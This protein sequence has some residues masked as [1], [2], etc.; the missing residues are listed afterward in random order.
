M[1]TNDRVNCLKGKEYQIRFLHL[2]FNNY[3]S[4]VNKKF[5]RSKF[6]CLFFFFSDR[7]APSVSHEKY[8][9]F[10]LALYMVD[11]HISLEQLAN[12]VIALSEFSRFLNSRLFFSNVLPV[13]FREVRKI[14]KLHCNNRYQ[15]ILYRS[16]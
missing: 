4:V 3:L 7:L 5:E 11:V 14:K 12:C 1:L 10:E 13:E 2:A 8:L 9:S 6:P 16:H 15:C